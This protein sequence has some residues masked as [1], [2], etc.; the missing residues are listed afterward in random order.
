MADQAKITLPKEP[1]FGE[2]AVVLFSKFVFWLGVY[3][4][5]TI[6]FLY[7]GVA[8]SVLSSFQRFSYTSTKEGTLN[9]NTTFFPASVEIAEHGTYNTPISDLTLPTGSYQVKVEPKLFKSF[10]KALQ[11]PI[12]ITP[13]AVTVAKVQLGVNYQTAAYFTVHSFKSASSNIIIYS[14]PSNALVS[15]ENTKGRTPLI[16]LSQAP[17]EYTIKIEKY[18]YKAVSIPITLQP[19]TTTVVFA[20]LYKFVISQ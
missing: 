6:T 15:F 3:V 18:G 12:Q 19:G 13:N 17:G 16:L 9:L 2:K 20:K 10:I 14:S 8:R 5:L 1:T 11:L 4:I 7:T